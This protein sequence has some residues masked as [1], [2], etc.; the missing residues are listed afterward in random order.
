[1]CSYSGMWPTANVRTTLQK[2]SGLIAA[3]LTPKAKSPSTR[4]L[5]TSR[6]G[7][8]VAD[9]S[10][11]EAQFLVSGVAHGH[12]TGVHGSGSYQR[13][14]VACI[15][16]RGKSIIPY[17]SQPSG[18]HRDRHSSAHTGPLSIR[19]YSGGGGGMRALLACGRCSS[20][21]PGESLTINTAVLDRLT[22]SR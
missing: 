1:M 13:R 6:L 20:L 12:P 14:A 3:L 2:G 19:S 15:H 8:V 5:A 18:R 16:L 10:E 9:V 7:G 4:L 11:C 21:L 17:R 22:T